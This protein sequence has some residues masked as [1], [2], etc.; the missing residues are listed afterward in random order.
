[1][2]NTNTNVNVNVG[3]NHSLG[4]ASFMVT[5]LAEPH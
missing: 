5:L 4:A 1:M 2:P 3:N